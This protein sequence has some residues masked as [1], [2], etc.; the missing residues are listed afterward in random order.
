MKNILV[1][2]A[3]RGI[4][5]EL[6]RQLASKGHTVMATCRKSNDRLQ[7][8]ASQV[9][10][11]IDVSDQSGI[12]HLISHLGRI[13]LDEVYIVAGILRSMGLESL[14]YDAIFE[15]FKVNAVGPLRA[16]SALAK[17]LPNGSKIGLLTSRMGSIADND[18]GGQYGYRMSK[19]ALNSAGKSLAIDLKDNGIAIALLHPGYVR[20]DMTGGNG[21]ID[22][23]ESAQGLINIM[24]Q[25]SLDNS[26][27]FWHTNGEELPW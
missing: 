7:S 11:H 19:S 3:N 14:D 25:L 9:I 13:Q 16:A 27:G 8:Y 2:G 20:T 6:V 15:Q 5:L 17:I 23:D 18:S 4:G 26:G 24:Q 1:V 12:D 22:V 10:D 21:L